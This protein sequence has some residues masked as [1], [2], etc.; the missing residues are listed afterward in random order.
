MHFS[1]PFSRTSLAVRYSP[2]SRV[3]IARTSPLQSTHL[4]HCKSVH[5]K[6]LP[7]RKT[8][9]QPLQN[10]SVCNATVSIANTGVI[11]LANATLTGV[12]AVTLLYATLFVNLGGMA[13]QG[14]SLVAQPFLA[15]LAGHPSRL[16]KFAS[17]W[18]GPDRR[19]RLIV[20]GR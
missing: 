7:A 20:G 14:S 1:R 9:L 19:A 2:I 13:D 18:F 11:T 8:R 17:T 15:V 16:P 6:Q 5:S 10:Q 3:S 12:S 4:L